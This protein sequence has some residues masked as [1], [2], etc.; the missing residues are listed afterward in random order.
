MEDLEPSQLLTAQMCQ[1]IA[2]KIMILTNMIRWPR[3]LHLMAFAYINIWLYK[4]M[5]HDQNNLIF[6]KKKKYFFEVFFKKIFAI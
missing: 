3:S 1:K 5:A 6:E 2:H 4:Y